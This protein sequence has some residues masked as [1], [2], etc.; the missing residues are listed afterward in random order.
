M[1]RPFA[2]NLNLP[3]YLGSATIDFLA[4]VRRP[5]GNPIP[6]LALQHGVGSF[7]RELCLSY[8]L[9]GEALVCNHTPV[10][11]PLAVG[12]LNGSVAG[13]LPDEIV[14]SEGGETMGIFGWAPQFPPIWSDSK[15]TVPGAF[16]SSALGDLDDDGDLDVLVGQS[17][18]SLADR[19]PSIHAF[20]WGATGLEQV[21]RPLPSTAGLDA[22]AIAD[23][24]SDGCN[25]VVGAGGYGRGMVHLGDGAGNFDG[26]RDLPQIGYQNAATATRVSMAVG[27]LSGDGRPEVVIAD[28]SANAVMVYRNASTPAGGPCF[29]APAIARDDVAVVTEDSGPTAIP[30]LANDS[31]PDG[32]PLVVAAVTQPAHGDSAISGGAVTYRP[33]AGYCNDLGAAPDTFTYTLVGGSTAT[34]AVTVQCVADVPPVLTPEA[35]DV[36]TFPVPGPGTPPPPAAIRSCV[37]P[38]IEKY[39]VGT[40]RRRRARRLQPTRHAQRPRRGRLPVRARR[41]RPAQRRYRE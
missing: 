18:N 6:L 36:P 7:G 38:G 25:D 32:G 31:D 22:V 34:V 23:V 9:D 4:L 5:D 8:D 14:T 40:P 17:V 30:V 11:G 20:L 15:R 13:I 26:G 39:I 1:T 27:D 41:R 3:P 2:F 37:Q 35:A 29:D 33:D 21:A 10:Q 16:E 24:D 12:D 19:V 28:R